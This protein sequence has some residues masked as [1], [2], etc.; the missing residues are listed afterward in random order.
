MEQL[1]ATQA[2]PAFPEDSV[3]APA[4]LTSPRYEKLRV[5]MLSVLPT[6]LVAVETSASVNDV[7]D[8]G[9]AFASWPKE[10]CCLEYACAGPM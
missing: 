8:S 5:T 6:Q 9:Q 1:P 7:G 10:E 3:N 2:S 4:E